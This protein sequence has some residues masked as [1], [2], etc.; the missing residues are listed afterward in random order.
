MNKIK[1]CKSVLGSRKKKK[2]TNKA[3]SIKDI[4]NV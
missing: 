4:K 3:E 2:K 1:R